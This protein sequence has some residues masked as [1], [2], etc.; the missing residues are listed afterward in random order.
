LPALSANNTQAIHHQLGS[1]RVAVLQVGFAPFP[2]EMIT[3]TE[4]K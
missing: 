3:E 4:A 1:G 2:V